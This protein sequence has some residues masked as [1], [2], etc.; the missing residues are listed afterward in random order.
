M[1]DSFCKTLSHIEASHIQRAAQLVLDALIEGRRVFVCGNG[2]SGA[3]SNLF[4]SLISKS[5]G[6]NKKNSGFQVISLNNNMGIIT[7]TA[8]AEGY[9]KI[10]SR[11]IENTAA[12]GDMLV[13][14][15]GSGN[16]PNI[17]E[18][19]ASAGKMGVYTIG[20]T[21]M[22][23]GKLALMSD[24]AVIVDSDS[25]EQIENVHTILIYAIVLWITGNYEKDRS[26][27]VMGE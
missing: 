19:V 20:L 22:G 23:G 27:S 5:C 1:K 25:M 3:N 8:Q 6:R 26:D 17:L 24:L 2:G 9:D 14:I 13:A 15:S 12:A 10:F 18:A 21:G 11:Q 7:G 4:S 16:S